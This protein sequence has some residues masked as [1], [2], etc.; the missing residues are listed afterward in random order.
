MPVHAAVVPG[1]VVSLM[2]CVAG[3]SLVQQSFGAG[4][5]LS[6]HLLVLL[7][8]FPLWG[9]LLAGATLAYWYRRRGRCPHCDR[10]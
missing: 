10:G 9:P 3:H 5:D 1:L 2:M 8:P 7:M 6:D 4:T